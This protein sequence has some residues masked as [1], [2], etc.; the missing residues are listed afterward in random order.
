M[1]RYVIIIFLVFLLINFRLLSIKLLPCEYFL[2]KYSNIKKPNNRVVVVFSSNK[3][4]KLK[5]FINS[6]LDQTVQVNIIANVINQKHQSIPEYISKT[7]NIYYDSSSMLRRILL[8]E[9]DNDSI[10]IRINSHK[11]YP[12]NFIETLIEKINN[13]NKIVKYEDVFVLK[14]SMINENINIYDENITDDDILNFN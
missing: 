3:V 10:I 13:S 11:I 7:T 14:P 6:I 12:R 2:S 8:K 5:P 1:N 4:D 9:T